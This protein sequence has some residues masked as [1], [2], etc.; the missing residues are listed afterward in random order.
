MKYIFKLA[1]QARD[2]LEEI[3]KYF[4]GQD[5]MEGD[6]ASP[7]DSDVSD[8]ICPDFETDMEGNILQPEGI[9]PDFIIDMVEKK[10]KTLYQRSW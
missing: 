1:L 5:L 3:I 4:E 8:N 2:L 6:R 7:E 10:K 9:D